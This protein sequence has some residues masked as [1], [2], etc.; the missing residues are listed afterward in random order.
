MKEF[1]FDYDPE[2]DDLFVYSEKE[3]SKGSVELGNL[4]FDFD[5]NRDLVALEIMD[6]SKFIQEMTGKDVV[7]NKKFLGSIKSCRLEIRQ[8]QNMLLIKLLILFENQEKIL[9]PITTPNVKHSS[10]VLSHT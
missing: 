6:A 8:H 3:K 7:I 2:N 1:K 9:V 5:S 10:P 4:I